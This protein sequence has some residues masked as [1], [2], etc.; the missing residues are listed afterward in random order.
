MIFLA[1]GSARKRASRMGGGEF[2][3]GIMREI[4]EIQGNLLFLRIKSRNDKNLD[5]K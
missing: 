5:K 3:L 2:F 4:F 1:G